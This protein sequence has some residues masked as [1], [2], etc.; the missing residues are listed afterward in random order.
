MNSTIEIH[1]FSTGIE[2]FGTPDDWS[3]GGFTGNYL[4]STL[5]FVR[6]K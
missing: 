1:E 3:I 5:E 4:N 6:Y 2:I